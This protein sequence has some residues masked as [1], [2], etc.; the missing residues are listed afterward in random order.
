MTPLIALLDAS[1][2]Y[3]APLRDLLIRLALTDLFAARWSDAIQDEWTRNLLEDR[4]DLGPDALARVRVLMERH[5]P[6]CRVTDYEDLIPTLTL[7]DPDDRHVLAAAIHARADV[8][9]TANIRH[10]PSDVL[11]RYRIT[12]QRPDDFIG[13]FLDQDA[14]RVL[15]AVRRQRAGL[16]RP[17]YTASELLDTLERQG[18]TQTV[19]RL[20][21]LAAQI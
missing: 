11:A 5:V 6:N 4:P 3:P 8:I 14:S 13:H 9:V 12:S 19:A 10:F 21:P 20:R 15:D 7:P 2:L 1:V 17:P 16:Q 18:L